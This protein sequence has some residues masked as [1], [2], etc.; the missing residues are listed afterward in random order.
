MGWKRRSLMIILSAVSMYVLFMLS[1]RFD[2]YSWLESY[3]SSVFMMMFY[4]PVYVVLCTI[5][6]YVFDWVYGRYPIRA[7]LLSFVAVI[8]TS[9]VVSLVIFGMGGLDDLMEM[10]TMSLVFAGYLAT[11][12]WYVWL[13]RIT[14]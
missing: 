4:G 8:V 1:A 9:G 10:P 11:Y 7:K 2:G 14:R 6:S 13:R 5:L 3:N 12:V